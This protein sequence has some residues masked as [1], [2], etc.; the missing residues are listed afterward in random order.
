MRQLIIAS[1]QLPAAWLIHGGGLRRG[2]RYFEND[3]WI[4]YSG[5][6]RGQA[7]HMYQLRLPN[8]LP[9]TPD[10]ACAALLKVWRAALRFAMAVLTVD[11]C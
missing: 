2:E 11:R 6:R 1:G 7:V 4:I 8:Q 5:I 3:K 10:E 9:G